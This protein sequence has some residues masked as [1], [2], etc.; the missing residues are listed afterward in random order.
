VISGSLYRASSRSVLRNGNFRIQSSEREPPADC[1]HAIPQKSSAPAG[2]VPSTICLP[3]AEDERLR[4]PARK[5]QQTNAY[6]HASMRS[7]KV[8]WAISMRRMHD[9][10]RLGTTDEAEPPCRDPTSC[11]WRDQRV[12]DK[13][14]LRR[15]QHEMILRAY[16][17][18]RQ[19][20]PFA[21]AMRLISVTRLL[22]HF[23]ETSSPPRARKQRTM[24]ASHALGRAGR[25]EG[26]T[27]YV[28]LSIHPKRGRASQLEF[29]YVVLRR[30]HEL[31]I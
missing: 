25:K 27:M 6:R 29:N 11:R 5:C 10:S 15:A 4:P 21:R 24:P 14:T 23:I 1:R 28:C 18:R 19:C 9:L 16:G 12:R 13:T 3:E 20:L 17:G 7:E 31:F 8:P 22:C 26:H 2:Y 30:G